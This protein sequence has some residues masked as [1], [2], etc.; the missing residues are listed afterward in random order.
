[1][2]TGEALIST[3]TILTI[4]FLAI[5][6]AAVNAGPQP[7]VT[8]RV[9]PSVLF[10]G[11]SIRVTCTVPRHPDNRLLDLGVTFY[12]GTTI[13]LDGAAARVTYEIIYDKVPCDSGP[14]YC[15]VTESHGR[16]YVDRAEI[17]VAGCGGATQ[18]R[19]PR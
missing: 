5:L 1:M 19:H 17:E 7:R 15:Q 11:H 13:Q 2:T 16:Q 9:L 4:G 8:I 6:N 10:A 14:A 18:K 3:L 12:R